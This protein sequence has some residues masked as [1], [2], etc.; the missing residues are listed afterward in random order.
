MSYAFTACILTFGWLLADCA[1][2]DVGKIGVL[3]TEAREA[4]AACD[5]LEKQ[6]RLIV[7]QAESLSTYIDSLKATDQ[8][9]EELHEALR[10][11]LGLVQQLVEIDHSLDRARAYE[12]SLTDRLRLEYDWE[13][14]VLIQQLQDRSD[15][16]L[17]TQL[18]VY[19]EARKAL[20]MAASRAV[21]RYD[22]GMDIEGDDGPEEIRQ[23]LELMDDLAQRLERE[24]RNLESRLSR[25]EDAYK[26]RLAMQ[27]FFRGQ[28]VRTNGNVAQEALQ[29]AAPAEGEKRGGI[30]FVLSVDGEDVSGIGIV[31]G[32]DLL[33][34]IQKWKVRQQELDE[35]KAV[36]RERS[37]TFRKYLQDM[38]RGP[39]D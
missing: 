5:W 19:Q 18:M 28:Q 21:L 1:R 29:V 12:D 7:A 35:L 38:L 10:E 27:S 13:I 25:L 14:G 32:E 8:E 24:G 2:A 37:T 15:G 39:D 4:S 26:L 9:L 3:R 22:E 16:G 23:K 31:P 34:E 17:L 6:R 20:G 36:V 30:G 33:L 11:S